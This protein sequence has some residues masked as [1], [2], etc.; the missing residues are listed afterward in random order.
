ME[1]TREDK[2][3]L[4]LRVAQDVDVDSRKRPAVDTTTTIHEIK[5]KGLFQYTPSAVDMK[6]ELEQALKA[7]DD[8]RNELTKLLAGTYEAYA[9]HAKRVHTMQ[10]QRAEDVKKIETLEKKVAELQHHKQQL[11]R[12]MYQ[13]QA[14]TKQKYGELDYY[15]KW[16]AELRALYGTESEQPVLN[17]ALHAEASLSVLQAEMKKA[18]AEVSLLRIQSQSDS[19]KLRNIRFKIDAWRKINPNMH[20]LLLEISMMCG[21]PPSTAAIAPPTSSTVPPPT[22]QAAAAVK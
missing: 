14:Q 1:T 10:Q 15:R 7:R 22:A 16:I 6:T 18:N 2:I 20:P 11:E 9:G 5:K 19:F 17:G 13:Q 12:V 4:L 8:A 3:D 21:S